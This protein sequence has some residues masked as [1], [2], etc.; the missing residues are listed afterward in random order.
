[1]F[2]SWFHYV[3]LFDLQVAVVFLRASFML[4]VLTVCKHTVVHFMWREDRFER[5]HV[6]S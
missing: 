4:C 6:F 1:M 3:R 5:C 2:K